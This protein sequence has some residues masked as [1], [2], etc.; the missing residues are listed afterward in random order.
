MYKRLTYLLPTYQQ[1][2]IE[3]IE[4][5]ITL[6][7]P[8]VIYTFINYPFN[9]QLYKNFITSSLHSSLDTPVELIWIYHIRLLCNH[10]KTFYSGHRPLNLY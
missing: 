9:L 4:Q 10:Y 6:W 3:M 8:R 2:L 5:S 1:T 7:I